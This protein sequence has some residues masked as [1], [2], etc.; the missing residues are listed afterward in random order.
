MND[1]NKRPFTG[2]LCQPLDPDIVYG[3]VCIKQFPGEGIT[4][5]LRPLSLTADE[6]LLREFA[7]LE[8]SGRKDLEEALFRTKKEELNLLTISDLGQSFMGSIDD[9]PAFLVTIHRMRQS[10]LGRRYAE[11]PGDYELQLERLPRVGGRDGD[12]F[13]SAI[14]QACPDCFFAFPEVGRLITT[15]DILQP[16][17]KQYCRA[18]GFRPLA[19]TAGGY[20]W[21]ELYIHAGKRS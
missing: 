10:N 8:L 16:G 6:T 7:L 3:E 15:L 20:E 19:R 11:Q 12:V 18:A 4:L 14:W 13:A 2:E 5:S 1:A 21:E 9:Q 17:E